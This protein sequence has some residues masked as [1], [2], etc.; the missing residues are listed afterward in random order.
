M[1]RLDYKAAEKMREIIFRML[2]DPDS[3]QVLGGLIQ[4]TIE[5]VDNRLKR[6]CNM[7]DMLDINY[8]TASTVEIDDDHASAI[9]HMLETGR[10]Q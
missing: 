9:M 10:W 3:V 4:F 8:D 7:V 5:R 2:A 1:I 6:F